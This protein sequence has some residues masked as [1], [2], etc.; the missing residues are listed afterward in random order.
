MLTA[1]AQDADTHREGEGKRGADDFDFPHI[2]KI[3]AKHPEFS[4]LNR[5][6]ILPERQLFAPLNMIDPHR[7]IDY[8]AYHGDGTVL[9]K[10]PKP[11]KS[12]ISG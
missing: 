12:S 5:T 4:D 10:P 3:L 1:R 8:F 2:L 7:Q 9:E 11:P 6:H